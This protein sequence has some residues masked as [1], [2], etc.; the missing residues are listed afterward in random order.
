MGINF[1]NTPGRDVSYE[2]IHQKVSNGFCSDKSE[3]YPGHIGNYHSS[4]KNKAVQ[5]LI[6]YSNSFKGPIACT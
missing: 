1:E 5:C 3:E 6:R 2:K 4:A